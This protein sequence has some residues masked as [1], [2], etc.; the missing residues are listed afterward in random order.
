MYTDFYFKIIVIWSYNAI[1]KLQ[2]RWQAPPSRLVSSDAELD[3]SNPAAG[4][5]ATR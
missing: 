4:G 2:F 3:N 5:G 1:L